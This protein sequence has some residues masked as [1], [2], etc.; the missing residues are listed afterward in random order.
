MELKEAAAR[1]TQ[2]ETLVGGEGEKQTNHTE[3]AGE[4]VS[5]EQDEP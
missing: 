4:A 3:A 1:N 2:G 5:L